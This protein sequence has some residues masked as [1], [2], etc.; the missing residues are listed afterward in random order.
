M[1]GQAFPSLIKVGFVIVKAIELP[2]KVSVLNPVLPKRSLS[3]I[4]ELSLYFKT[5]EQQ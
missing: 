1:L 2:L 3:A 5:E 4:V